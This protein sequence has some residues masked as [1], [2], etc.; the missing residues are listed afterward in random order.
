M[1]PSRFARRVGIGTILVL[2]AGLSVVP[3]S[4]WPTAKPPAHRPSRPTP[5]AAPG[6]RPPGRPR[7]A[8]ARSASEA[9]GTYVNAEGYW[10]TPCPLIATPGTACGAPGVGRMSGYG[11]L[12]GTTPAQPPAGAWTPRGMAALRPAVPAGSGR[13][14][15]HV[16][17][18]RPVCTTYSRYDSDGRSPARDRVP[19]AWRA[20]DLA[21]V[22]RLNARHAARALQRWCAHPHAGHVC[23]PRTVTPASSTSDAT[24]T[25]RAPSRPGAQRHDGADGGARR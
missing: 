19:T 9:A 15:P 6:R 20:G 25:T 17:R 16:G 22:A 2:V 12:A 24:S 1:T 10:A 3:R 7:R 18:R 8:V 21:A 13:G 5:H 11:M 23:R 14:V 4:G